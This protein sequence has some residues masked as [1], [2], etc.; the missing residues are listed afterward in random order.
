MG[1]VATVSF[2]YAVGIAQLVRAPDC[3]SGGREFESLYSPHLKGC[4]QAVRHETL[5]FAL[6]GPNP[7]TPAI[8]HMN[9]AGL[10]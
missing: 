5:T 4:R 3:G 7:A 1:A 8:M 6:A 2:A 10:I 9:L